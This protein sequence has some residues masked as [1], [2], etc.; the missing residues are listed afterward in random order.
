MEA[1]DSETSALEAALEQSG[2]VSFWGIMNRYEFCQDIVA[3]P[4][5]FI[6]DIYVMRGTNLYCEIASLGYGVGYIMY[7]TAY[8]AEQEVAYLSPN[9]FHAKFE[10]Y[11]SEGG[12]PKMQQEKDRD[13]DY[14]EYLEDRLGNQDRFSEYDWDEEFDE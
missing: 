3:P 11:S 9:E 14:D 12:L 13:Q 8:T 4:H 6:G 7:R 5:I 2:A 1:L 10:C